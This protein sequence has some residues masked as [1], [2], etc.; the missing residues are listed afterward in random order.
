MPPRSHACGSAPG[1]GE[2]ETREELNT[3]AR[4]QPDRASEEKLSPPAPGRGSWASPLVSVSQASW[5]R[6]WESSRKK[7]GAVSTMKE[8]VSADR[9]GKSE[10]AVTLQAL[11]PPVFLLESEGRESAGPGLL[12]VSCLA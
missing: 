3:G 6:L 8:L 9:A 11:S 5:R 10:F 4:V 2:T 7:G 12:R 1:T